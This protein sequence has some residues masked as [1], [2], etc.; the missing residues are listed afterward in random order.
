[1]YN[2]G[3]LKIG[4]SVKMNIGMHYIFEFLSILHSLL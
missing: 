2:T 1:M 4:V 3:T